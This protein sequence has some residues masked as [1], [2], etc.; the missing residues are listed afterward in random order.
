PRT[1]TQTSTRLRRRTA[2]ALW[3]MSSSSSPAKTAA[4]RSHSLS[5]PGIALLRLHLVKMLY[6]A[7]RSDNFKCLCAD[8]PKCGRELVESLAYSH[9][10]YGINDSE[11]VT[12][13]CS[14]CS[15]DWQLP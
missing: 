4:S 11:V 2:S 5:I 3:K 9:H 12:M 13:R 15:H 10:R 6:M 14:A 7:N 1:A 8:C